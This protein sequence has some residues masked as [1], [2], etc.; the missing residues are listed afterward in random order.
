MVTKAVF[1]HTRGRYLIDTETR[2]RE[3][4]PPNTVILDEALTSDAYGMGGFKILSGPKTLVLVH[5][6]CF[7]NMESESF[8][9]PSSSCL[10]YD[11]NTEQT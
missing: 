1:P 3:S 8:K 9:E 4:C 7:Q 6:Q 2:G 5:N 11:W 10:P